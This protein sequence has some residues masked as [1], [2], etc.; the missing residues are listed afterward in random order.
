MNS[1]RW[2]WSSS[3]IGARA[4]RVALIPAAGIFRAVTIA[5]NALYSA[6]IMRAEALAVP[7]IS[8]GNLTV[9]GTGKTPV[10]QWIASE[11][12]SRGGRPAILLRGYG[13]DEAL[14]HRA[15]NPD[16][17]VVENAD[18]V[19]G[20]REAHRLG[21]DIVVLD[22]G[23]QH[24][25]AARTS[26]I[27]L[28]SADAMHDSHLPLP[29]GP[30]RESITAVR[31]ADLVIVTRKAAST[32]EAAEV[33]A[34]IAEIA[35]EVPVAISHLSPDALVEW[36]TRRIVPV[37]EF[38]GKD[39]VIV[40]GIGNPGAFERQI[41]DCGVRATALRFADHHAFTPEETQALL[42]RVPAGSVVFCTLKDAVKLGPLWPREGPP[43]WYVS[44]CVSLVRGG[45][46]LAGLLDAALALRPVP[47][48]P[49]NP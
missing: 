49:L 39:A 24:R 31:R 47:A 23:F 17:I 27:V 14:V 48:V 25:R 22:D 8:V 36:E 42:S 13:Q 6:G 41:A 9:G 1:A 32:A 34:R 43:L 20:A 7:S 11:L 2:L 33:A 35:P 44:Q 3:S 26:D 15:L 46:F 16:V 4:A 18:R 29:A 5:R 37:R 38:A 12:L 45:D 40:S 10:S 30:W 19:A 28:V 21:A